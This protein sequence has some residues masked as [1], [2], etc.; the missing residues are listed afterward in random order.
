MG[1]RV[2]SFINWVSL[3]VG[4][5]K[6]AF[7]SNKLQLKSPKI[8]ISLFSSSICLISFSKWSK[9]SAGEFGGRLL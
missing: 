5:L 6:S 8:Y 7:S 9:N 3:F 4:A 2:G 1:I